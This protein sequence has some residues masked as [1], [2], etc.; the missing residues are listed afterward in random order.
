MNKKLFRGRVLT[1]ERW[2]GHQNFEI[3][4]SDN[5]DQQNRQSPKASVSHPRLKYLKIFGTMG[6]IP[7]DLSLDVSFRTVAFKVVSSK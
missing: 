5:R 3:E 7:A 6:E 1:V 2:D 4:V